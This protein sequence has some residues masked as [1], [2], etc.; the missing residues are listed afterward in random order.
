MAE[1]KIPIDLKLS[2]QHES[3]LRKYTIVFF[4]MYFF[5]LT[6]L[7]FL[8]HNAD[9]SSS[10]FLREYGIEIDKNLVDVLFLLFLLS[11]AVS[12]LW[13]RRIFLIFLKI[14][15]KAEEI[16]KGDL[17]QRLDVQGD[18]EIVEL[19]RSFNA[20]TRKLEEN[21]ERLK[22]SKRMV[23]EVLYRISTGMADP[24]K[25][26]QTFL[27]LILET[28]MSA[29]DSYRGA[30][31][32]LGEDDLSLYVQCSQGYTEEELRKKTQPGSEAE[33]VI[34][35]SRPVIVPGVGKD[36]E[37]SICVPLKHKE[38]TVGVLS[39]SG[40]IGEADFSQ[41]D[42]MLLSNIATQTAVAIINE[43]LNLDAEQTYK[44]TVSALAVAVE[45]RDAYSRGHSDRV[46]KYAV[47]VAKKI[48][49]NEEAISMIQDAAELHDVGKIGI[50][51]EVLRKAGRLTQDE[52]R[53]M[54][55]H[56][57]I[58]ESIVKPIRS[59]ANLCDLIRHHHEFL[60]GTGYPDGLKADEVNTGARILAVADAYDAMTTDRPYRKALT[61]EEAIAELRKFAPAH[62]DEKIVEAFVD[63][64][65]KKSDSV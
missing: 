56:P 3:L 37:T 17:S 16:S 45:A 51:D 54:R 20:I 55:K 64:L 57:E 19:A 10:A 1:L 6:I 7:F 39:F 2:I 18:K 65:S 53:I 36:I 22:M 29:V 24:T 46:S 12:F 61:Q 62:Y 49:L 23:Q 15:K 58:G 38:K 48:G 5:P 25:S 43:R 26:T 63:G 8:F 21:I 27:K 9:I 4:T 41:D 33:L 44:Q 34:R 32:L 60:D 35:S 28:T 11:S 14:T 40:K 52:M 47:M 59:L 13:G 30:L 31:I 42:I 50:E